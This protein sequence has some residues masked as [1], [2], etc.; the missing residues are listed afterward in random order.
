M[1]TSP[2]QAPQEAALFRT[3]RG[4]GITRGD[5]GVVG[6]VVEGLGERIGM[7]RVPAR[8]I[9]V[10]AALVLNGMILLAYAAAWALLPD[11]KGNIIVQNF[12]R[13]IPNVGAL[14][15][16]AILA[17]VG[18]SDLDHRSNFF[19]D[20]G[21]WSND[22]PWSGSGASDL[23][24]V[25]LFILAV[26]VPVL[27][28]GAVIT[29]IV[30]LVK[31]GNNRPPAGPGA[32]YAVPPTPSS[33]A[34]APGTGTPAPAAS[35]ST[36]SASDAPGSPA[37]ASEAHATSAATLPPAHQW[38]PAPPA[39][40]LPPRLPRVPGPG[41]SFYLLTLAWASIAIASV[42]WLAREDRLAVHP[43]VASFVLFVTGLGII[44]MLISLA[45]R[46]LGFLGF[47]GFVALIPLLVFAGNADG[48]R[49]AYADHGGITDSVF[50]TEVFPTEAMPTFEPTPPFDP[51]LQFP[52][53][54]SITSFDGY[55]E[56]R[57]WE[58]Y[59]ANSVARVNLASPVAGAPSDSTIDISA[60]VTYVTIT[61]G[62]SITVAGDE[63]AQANVVF[64]DRDFMCDFGN[65]GQQYLA[66]TNPG[67]PTINLVVHDDQYANTI[68]IK[69]VTS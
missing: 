5:H 32:V 18:L 63:N 11:R 48:L 30:L 45:G 44:L 9:V 50:Y 33:P 46:K 6:G 40:P 58:D 4:W 28:V 15:G 25:I 42:V 20:P 3:I 29:A 59:G 26:A 60:E 68:V 47:V 14:I 55:C 57:T 1:S 54:Y 51:T 23:G 8:I 22:I 19:F 12:G 7:A 64:A 2:E 52:G 67:T 27:V 41:R 69:E 61:E 17:L 10:V 31:R 43:V 53:L 66:L 13:G 39:P 21:S 62:T 34:A 35:P 24:R 56:Q 65:T 38:A 16:I 36:G 49:S 37:T